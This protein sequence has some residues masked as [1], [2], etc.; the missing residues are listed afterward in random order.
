MAR[1]SQE[2]RAVFCSV[3][4]SCNCGTHEIAGM[5]S[6]VMTPRLLIQGVLLACAL[7]VAG[8]RV[9]AAGPGLPDPAQGPPP[10][11]VRMDIPA[12]EVVPGS[13][14]EVPVFV[15]ADEALSMVAVSIELD[16]SIV[17]V[18]DVQPSKGIEELLLGERG[19][20]WDFEWFLNKDDGWLQASLVFDFKARDGAGLPPGWHES[21]LS[22]SLEVAAEATENTV[23]LVFTRAEGARYRGHF[24]NGRGPVY[25]TARGHGRPF[26]VN[27][28][29]EDGTEPGLDDGALVVRLIG[30]IGI[31]LRGDANG[32]LGIDIS[33]AITVLDFLFLGAS[34]PLP[35]EDAADA[36]DDGEIDVSDP[37]TVLLF[38]FLGTEESTLAPSTL[39]KDETPDEIGCVGY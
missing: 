23:P 24:Q 5:I 22:L 27:D 16:T 13:Q 9:R 34:I 18:V 35:C 3:S 2:V 36:N 39:A 17:D 37:V 26:S 25:N 6:Q 28:K 4:P 15:E 29:F 30:D 19:V 11:S 20:D 1:T 10:R 33:D 21:V 7:A 32:D 8:P 31:F 14:I 38:L 12:V